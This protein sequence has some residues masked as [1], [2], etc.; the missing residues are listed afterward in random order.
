MES[1]ALSELFGADPGEFVTIRDR[2]AKTLRAQ[3]DREEATAV[4]ALRRPTVAAWALNQVARRHPSVVESLLAA[5]EQARAA[6]DEVLA[7]GDR[8][9]LR[10]ALSDRR[11]ALHDVTDQV[12]AIVEQSGRPPESTARDVEMALQGPLGEA[13]IER[14]RRGELSDLDTG[15]AE[16]ADELSAL[17][18]AS[19]REPTSPPAVDA[20]E[21]RRRQ[22]ADE[23]ARLE[24]AVG[25]AASRLADAEH[26]LA[27]REQAVR[28]AQQRR[29]E[30]RRAHDHAVSALERAQV[31]LDG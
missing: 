19:V 26:V 14:L 4:R 7:G 3:G 16:D 12:R 29:D 13:F 28:D 2:L 27:D 1:E 10:T 5:V 17:L 30:A 25:E 22:R 11:Q 8:A 31:E 23:V 24:A 9:T 15:G 18:S 20:D 6:Q 21:V